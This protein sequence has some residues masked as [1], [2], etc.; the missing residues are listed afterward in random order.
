MNV[1]F[2]AA[3]M[4]QP[5]PNAA[6]SALSAGGLY[7]Y[8]GQVPPQIQAHHPM[9][10]AHAQ[11]AQMAAVPPQFTA[12][13]QVPPPPR[14]SAYTGGHPYQPIMYW[15]PSPPVSPQSSYYLHASPTT[16]KGEVCTF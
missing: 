16:L 2:F 13:Q 3:G 4:M 15:Y 12:L 14:P 8:G 10:A 5:S 9:I 7:P 1:I 11:A 6:F